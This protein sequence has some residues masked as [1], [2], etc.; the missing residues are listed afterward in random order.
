M[1]AASL[2]IENFLEMMLVERDASKNTISSYR[3]DLEKFCEHTKTSID[4]VKSADIRNYIFYLVRSS[5]EAQ[6]IARKLSAIRHFFRYL[7]EEKIISDNPA[8]EID[9]PKSNKS[10]PDV[11]SESE[12]VSLLE[13][14]SSKDNP[15][16]LRDTTMLEILYATGMRVSELVSLKIT[17]IK[18]EKNV[19]Q[20]FIE[21]FGKGNKERMVA[22]NSKSTEALKKYLPLRKMLAKNEDNKWL[23]PSKLSN[24][25]H[26]TRQYFAKT[27]KKLALNAGINPKKISPHKIRHSFAT[28][29]LNNGADLRTIQELLGH[30]DISTTQIYTHV[31]NQKLKDTIEKFHPLS[32]D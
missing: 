26:I 30:E 27:L 25:G 4:D 6:T 23:F 21:I 13:E 22:L 29:L 2:H 9:M 3:S 1:T 14:A 20:P 11:L 16:S 7:F 8:L 5:F 15:E 18:M 10:L 17:Q 12:V 32:K 31:A 28:H 24:E 19:I